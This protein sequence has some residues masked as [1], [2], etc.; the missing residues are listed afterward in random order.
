[1]SN[2]V[3]DLE[4][5]KAVTPYIQPFQAA[6]QMP[7]HMAFTVPQASYMPSFQHMTANPF[8]ASPQ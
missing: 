2:R 8:V 7:G 1:M 6:Q 3:R 5:N 4:K